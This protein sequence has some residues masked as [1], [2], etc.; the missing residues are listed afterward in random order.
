MLDTRDRPT[1][2]VQGFQNRVIRGFHPDPSV[3][4]VGDEYFLA[5]VVHVLPR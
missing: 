1:V 3:C 2:T 5:T 4:R